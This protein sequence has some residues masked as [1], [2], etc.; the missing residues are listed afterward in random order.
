MDGW[1]RLISICVPAPTSGLAG[2]LVTGMFY[3]TDRQLV[4]NEGSFQSDTC[5]V[6]EVDELDALEIDDMKDLEVAR[7]LIGME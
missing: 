1:N 4:M 3:F 2:E 5:T 6:V 7:L